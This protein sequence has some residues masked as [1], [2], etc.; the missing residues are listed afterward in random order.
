MLESKTHRSIWN[1]K[2]PSFKICPKC[3]LQL[4]LQ[5]LKLY[6]E[7]DEVDMPSFHLPAS[8]P[9]V[10]TSCQTSFWRGSFSSCGFSAEAVFPLGSPTDQWKAYGCVVNSPKWLQPKWEPRF[11]AMMGICSF[12]SHFMFLWLLWF[13][14]GCLRA[15]RIH[16]LNKCNRHWGREVNFHLVPALRQLTI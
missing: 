6:C 14:S 16:S 3:L 8:A 2:I 10:A 9:V 11:Y 5:D 15:Q 1:L 13:M 7:S 12:F 4:M